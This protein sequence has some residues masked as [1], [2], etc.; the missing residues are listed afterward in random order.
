MKPETRYIGI[1]AAAAYLG[2]SKS[3]LYKLAAPARAAIPTYK[4]GGSV[5]FDREELDRWMESKRRPTAGEREDAVLARL[6]KRGA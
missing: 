6:R 3:T 5:R 2:L 1:A 4:V